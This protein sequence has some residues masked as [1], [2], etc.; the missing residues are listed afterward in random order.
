M[1]T[2]C[3]VF[4]LNGSSPHSCLN[5]PEQWWE[6]LVEFLVRFA[7]EDHNLAVLAHAAEHS[8]RK[9]EKHGRSG[10]IP[11]SL[12][13]NDDQVLCAGLIGCNRFNGHREII[14]RW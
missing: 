7:E 1:L 5:R 8:T 9:R 11:C 14:L 6:A 13:S 4:A 12:G 10:V 3:R 2:D